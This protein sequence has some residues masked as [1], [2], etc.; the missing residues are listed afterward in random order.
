M[1]CS[2]SKDEDL[3]FWG[4]YSGG[5]LWQRYGGNEFEA[6]LTHIKELG[7][8]AVR[9]VDARYL[10]KLAKKRGGKLHRRQDLPEEAFLKLPELKVMDSGPGQSLRVVV[11]SYPW[12][13]PDHPDPR[14]ET[15]RL[16]ACVL[17]AYI[18][19]RGGTCGVFL[20]FC[21]LMQ[22]G[23]N[24]EERTPAQAKL[25]GLA[26]G[27]LSDWYSH[28]KTT[29]LKLTKM[30]EG[31]PKGF[32][33]VKGTVPNTA[34]YYGRG[35]CF[36]ESS[37][38]N[39]VKYYEYSLDLGKLRDD[40]MTRTGIP[41]Q[42]WG[43]MVSDCKA[44]RAPPMTPEDFAT[45]LE[46]K[47]FTSKKADLPTVGGLYKAAYTKRFATATKLDY[48]SL[49]WGDAEVISLSKVLESGAIPNLEQL[50]LNWNQI[51]DVGMQ[52][53]A[54][55]VSNGALPKLNILFITSPSAELKALCSSK[56]IKLNTTR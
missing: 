14:G 50:W 7:G 4:F 53:L 34:D 24:G 39:M 10:I 36:K 49:G 16:L 1:G 17:K 40:T 52:A 22:K 48:G 46:R 51:G 28:P 3:P 8:S 13:Q 42:A 15:L 26:L 33:F 43:S 47:S 20:D 35:W 19:Q 31:Y 6:A 5:E 41:G 56:S 45:E 30:P 25:F 27:N 18:A 11:V 44:G 29:V 55:A 32:T 23:P 37:V 21:S 2:A 12:L 54:G 38:A 9:L